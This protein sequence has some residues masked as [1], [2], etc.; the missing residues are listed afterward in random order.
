MKA[1]LHLLSVLALSLTILP[2][3]LLLSGKLPEGIMKWL[4]LGGTVAWFI[5]WPLATRPPVN[6]P[7]SDE[8]S[9]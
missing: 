8:P 4:M 1:L 6:P 7:P 3:L 9:R 2:P 5:S